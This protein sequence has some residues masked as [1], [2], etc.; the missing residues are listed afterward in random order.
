MIPPPGTSAPKKFAPLKA[1]LWGG[2]ISG[3][4][5]L[6]FALLFYGARGAKSLNILQSIAGGLLGR[7]AAREG[8]AATAVLGV[9]LHYLIA[10][11]WAALFFVAS[12]RLPMLIQ[13]T[14]ASGLVYGAFVY[15]AMNMIVL[16]LSALHSPAWPPN[17][18]LWPVV[19]HLVGVGLPI[20]L[21]VRAFAPRAEPAFTGGS[22]LP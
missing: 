17:V 22:P 8:G 12:R 9:S 1:I 10:S 11:I 18:A 20:A 4:C 2:L 15:L 21:A 5:D 7:T 3:T 14:I 13:H 6:T 16:P 19:I